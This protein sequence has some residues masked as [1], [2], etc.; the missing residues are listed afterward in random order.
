MPAPAAAGGTPP[1]GPTLHAVADLQDQLLSVAND[2]ERLEGLLSA[3]CDDLLASFHVSSA[4]VAAALSSDNDAARGA[5]LHSLCDAIT[6]LQFQ[7][8]ASQLIG[9]SLRRLAYCSDRLASEA[10]GDNDDDGDTLV[11][12]APQRANPVAQRAMAAG[13]VELF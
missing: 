11:Q 10:F 3:A 8:M 7:D 9:H 12:P 4:T 13:S 6:G 2:L 5:A 1:S